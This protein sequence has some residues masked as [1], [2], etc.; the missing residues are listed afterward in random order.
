MFRGINRASLMTTLEDA[1][2]LGS[3]LSTT[4]SLAVS[5]PILYANL[6]EPQR[7][8]IL[9]PHLWDLS[10][11]YLFK[12]TWLLIDAKVYEELY[13][14]SYSTYQSKDIFWKFCH[15]FHQPTPVVNG[16]KAEEREEVVRFLL[17]SLKCMW[18]LIF[19]IFLKGIVSLIFG[20]PFFFAPVTGSTRKLSQRHQ[21]DSPNKLLYINLWYTKCVIDTFL[22]N[23]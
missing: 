15:N 23:V 17:L 3:L 12:I 20:V 19:S 21:V 16:S 14:N 5:D 9:H 8:Y 7:I 2:K 4:F 11:M 10:R 1:P 18:H 6:K 22:S 13:W